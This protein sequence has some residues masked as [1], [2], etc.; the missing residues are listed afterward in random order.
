MLYPVYVQVGDKKHAHGI[1][2]PDFPGC[3]SAAD[4]W[5]E[6]TAW[7]R[8]PWSVTWPVRISHSRAHRA[9]KTCRRL[10]LPGRRM[11]AG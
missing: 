6:I 1:E 3:F 10:A 2:F 11:D 4:D 9:G 5:Q 7:R 8:R